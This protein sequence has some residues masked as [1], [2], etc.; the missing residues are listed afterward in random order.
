MRE[1]CRNCGNVIISSFGEFYCPR[2][3]AKLDYIDDAQQFEDKDVDSVDEFDNYGNLRKGFNLRDKDIS[4]FFKE[5]FS[6]IKTASVSVDKGFASLDYGKLC[7]EVDKWNSVPD[8]SKIAIISNPN[9][10][11][12]QNPFDLIGLFGVS[13]SEGKKTI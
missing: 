3:G 9:D 11:K 1:V 2:C 8:P 6:I 7:Q 10:S 5:L 12:P 4:P 13:E